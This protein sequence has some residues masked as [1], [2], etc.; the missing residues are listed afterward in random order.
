MDDGGLEGCIEEMRGLVKD[1]SPY[2]DMEFPLEEIAYEFY[3][4]Y[5]KI[6]GFG[7]GKDYCNKSKKDGVM[8]S[9]M[10]VCYMVGE[11]EKDNR[12]TVIKKN[13]RSE[14]RTNCNAFMH[15]SFK[16]D[17]SKWIVS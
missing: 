12:Y 8:T 13:P 6:V 5:R 17:L 16:Q 1:K 4:E 15:I 14:T 11:R 9:R 7:I 10:F 3:N 2:L